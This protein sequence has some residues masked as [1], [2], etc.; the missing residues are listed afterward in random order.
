MKGDSYQ[1]FMPYQQGN[2]DEKMRDLEWWQWPIF[3][4]AI[5]VVF[6]CFVL[7]YSWVWIRYRNKGDFVPGSAKHNYRIK[8]EKGEK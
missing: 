6:V 8:P 1:K 3:C 4:V 7:L 5:P 2:F